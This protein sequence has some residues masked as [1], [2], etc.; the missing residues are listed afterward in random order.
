MAITDTSRLLLNG[1]TTTETGSARK[2]IGKKFQAF[3]T[4]SSG[5][6]AATIIVEVSL[7]GDNWMTLGTISLT[8]GTSSTSDGFAAAEKWDQ[9]RGRVSA[10][11]GTGAAVTLVMGAE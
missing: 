8:L 6:G 9:V 5:S 2:M 10:I 3:G 11:S 1:S 7:D 4:T